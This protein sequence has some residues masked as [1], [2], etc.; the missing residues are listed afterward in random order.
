[1]NY[2]DQIFE[3]AN[4]QHIREFLF[5]GCEAAQINA[6]PY[7]ERLKA[8]EKIVNE[9]LRGKFPDDEEY[10]VESSKIYNYVSASQEVYMEVGMQVGAILE[11]Q[12]LGLSCLP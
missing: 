10:N 5:H 4:L 2:V 11:A 1:M 8:P 9:M 12:L 6:M 7:I 3:R